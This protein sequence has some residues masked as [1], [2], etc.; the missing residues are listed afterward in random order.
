MRHRSKRHNFHR[1]PGPRVA[2]IRGMVYSLVE[3][4]R[5]K[6]TVARAKEIRRHV[7]KAITLGKRGG[8][9]ARRL[10]LSRLPNDNGVEILTGDLPKRFAKREGGYTRIVRVGARAGDQA[11]MAFLEFVD[12]KPEA[13]AG[14]ETVKGDKTAKARTR[15]RTKVKAALRKS[16]RRIQSKSRSEARA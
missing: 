4:G 14:D 5:I 13:K 3:N 6:T 16:V 8:L 10:L 15:A 2:L 7:E 9:N 11:D 1:R 12:Y